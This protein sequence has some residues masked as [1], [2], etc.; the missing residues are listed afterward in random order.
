MQVNQPRPTTVAETLA[1]WASDLPYTAV[2]DDVLDMTK[3]LVLDQLGLQVRGSTMP[4]VQPEL[5]LVEDMAAAPE[6]TITNTSVRTTAAQAAYVN[7]TFGHSTEFD[8]CH[9]LAWHAGSVIVPAGIAI[10]EREALGGRDLLQALVTGHQVMSTLGG[11]Y[12]DGML[13]RGWHGPKALGGFASAAVTGRLIGLSPTALANAFAITASDASGTMEYDRSGGEVKRLHAGAASRSGVEAAL[14]SGHGLT[15]PLT[16]FEGPRGMFRMFGDVSTHGSLED[17][18]SQWHLRD[19]M[20]RL[21]PGV[22]TVLSALD[23]VGDLQSEHHIDWRDVVSVR[24]GLR[25]FAVHH[26]GAIVHPT[27]GVSA[28]FSLAFALALRLVTGGSAPEDYLSPETWADPTIRKVSE[29]VRPYAHEFDEG[30]PLL[31]SHVEIELA[32]GRIF[33]RTQ[34]GFSGSADRPAGR[35]DIVGKFLTNISGILTDDDARAVLDMVDH[36]EDL[37]DISRLTRRLVPDGA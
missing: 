28:H 32:D 19:T 4:N 8:D 23:L 15:G 25:A 2:P 30:M 36:L 13:A 35:E 33:S 22:G 6:A 21:N 3:M 34:G 14:L 7:G 18:W 11:V 27:D 29:L 16:I 20:F 12:T 24:V 9:L 31:S 1:R 5:R 26:G 10:A 17:L 37:D